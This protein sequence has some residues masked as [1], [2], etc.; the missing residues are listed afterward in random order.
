MILITSLSV[1]CYVRS[2]VYQ[3]KMKC[4]RTLIGFDLSAGEC[5]P[6]LGYHQ[7][8]DLL[9]GIKSTRAL[10]FTHFLKG[11]VRTVTLPETGSE[12]INPG[13]CLLNS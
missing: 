6:S 3:K 7:S 5:A 10:R 12:L 13:R 11:F 4:P 2:V 9:E 1:I 8:C